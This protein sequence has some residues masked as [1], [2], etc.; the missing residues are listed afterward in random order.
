MFGY[1]ENDIISRAH[2]NEKLQVMDLTYASCL[3]ALNL[4]FSAMFVSYAQTKTPPLQTVRVLAG[5][6]LASV[7][8][9][10]MVLWTNVL[11][12]IYVMVAFAISLTF[13]IVVL[14]NPSDRNDIILKTVGGTSIAIH[15]ILL[16]VFPIML[17]RRV[18]EESTGPVLGSLPSVEENKTSTNAFKHNF[19]NPIGLKKRKA[20][21]L[22]QESLAKQ[23]EYAQL[24]EELRRE[25]EEGLVSQQQRRTPP[26]PPPSSNTNSRQTPEQVEVGLAEW[27]D[28]E[29]ESD[30]ESDNGSAYYDNQGKLSLPEGQVRANQEYLE[31][32][33]ISFADVQ[34]F[35]E[36]RY[37]KKN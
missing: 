26:P 8:V 35:V 32:N 25:E 29:Y 23:K 15:G 3:V 19:S 7:V 30:Y 31:K 21:K 18:A 28:S 9:S 34:K 10:A 11:T 24:G 27:S 36:N 37:P 17:L 1:G 14:Q 13:L 20:K 16:F 4:G 2:D 12:M 22:R 33:K 5:V 6:M